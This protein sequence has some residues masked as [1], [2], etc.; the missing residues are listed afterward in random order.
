MALPKGFKLYRPESD[1]SFILANGSN[2][3][4]QRMAT[5]CP[6]AEVAGTTVIHGYRMLFKQSC[7]G[8]YATIEQDANCHVPAV[9]YRVMP[10]DEAALDRYEG[11]PKYYY[12]KEFL[13]PVWNPCG[14]KLRKRR[15][16]IAYILHEDR[17]LGE[18]PEEYYRIIEKGYDDWGFDTEV[19]KKALADS[20][21]NKA[22]AK[23]L[24][25]HEETR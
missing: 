15:C 4:W 8:A 9:V 20:I 21:G 25:K 14:R 24:K 3:L 18:P 16:C 10:M 13:L 6:S 19:L 5:R 7:T 23:W 22:A 2:L 17:M 12:K 1:P 11:C